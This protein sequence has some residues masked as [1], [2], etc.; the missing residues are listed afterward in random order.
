VEFDYSTKSPPPICTSVLKLADPSASNIRSCCS[1]DTLTQLLHYATLAKIEVDAVVSLITTTLENVTQELEAVRKLIESEPQAQ[2][3]KG[4][5]DDVFNLVENYFKSI[6]KDFGHCLEGIRRYYVGVLCTLCRVDLPNLVEIHKN[7]DNTTWDVTWKWNPATCDYLYGTCS[8][9]YQHFLNFENALYNKIKQ[10][11]PATPQ[12]HS[13][14]ENYTRGC[15]DLLC[16]SAIGG[17]DFHG[18]FD[19]YNDV[20]DSG[21]GNIFGDG[22]REEHPVAKLLGSVGVN[23]KKLRSRFADWSNDYVLNAKGKRANSSKRQQPLVLNVLT[24]NS[25]LESSNAQPGVTK[26]GME[27]TIGANPATTLQIS[28]A[29]LAMLALFALVF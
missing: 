4:I 22:K 7:E 25:Y 1:N 18:L 26:T 19:F 29:F 21:Y 3:Y 20:S 2:Q 17:L 9:L 14:C 10:Y 8:P 13:I 23:L 5:I 11:N 27:T 15:K 6:P 16:L 24:T 28:F 12:P